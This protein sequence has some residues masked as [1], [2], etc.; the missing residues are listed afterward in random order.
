MHFLRVAGVALLTIS[1]VAALLHVVAPLESFLAPAATTVRDVWTLIHS[2]SPQSAFGGTSDSP[3]SA[4]GF[5][6]VFW[7]APAWMLI[8]AAGL[9]MLGLH[10]T[11]RVLHTLM[12]RPLS[13]NNSGERAHKASRNAVLYTEVGAAL[14]SSRG[15]FLGAA[16]FSGVSNL[17]M[18]TGSF[19]ML[20]VY[21]RVLPSRSIPTLVALSCLVVILFT[22]QG[23]L[24]FIRGRILVRAAIILD[25]SLG[26]RV[27]ETAVRLPLYMGA[28]LDPAQPVRDL[29]TVRSFL[30][31][32]GPIA[33]F[34][35]PWV[36]MYLGII[37]IFH[38]L[39]GAVALIGAILLIMLTLLTEFRTRGPVRAATEYGVI[40]QRLT[41]ASTRNAEVLTAIGL[42]KR[43]SSRW[44]EANRAYIN[45]QQRASDV[46]GGFTA[47]SRVLRM[48]LQ[49][50]VLAVG[51][52]LV[53]AQEATAGIIIAGAILMARALAPVDLAIANWQGFVK[54]RQ[55]WQRLSGL[56]AQLPAK[57]Q[58]LRLPAPTTSLRVESVSVAPPGEQT[59]AL[60][61][62]TFALT[63]G[64]GL[65]IIGPSG[66]G[67]SS[68][69]RAMV[70]VWPLVRGRIS[71]DRASLD[72]W[73]AEDLGRAVGYLPQ[74]VELFAGT[75]AENI[76]RFDEEAD[77]QAI[78]AAA[79]LAAVHDLI[80]SLPQGYETRIGEPGA[81]LSPGQQQRIALARALYG[82]P[83]LV[84]LD[85]PD[86]SLDMEGQLALTR[87][88]PRVRA[89]GGIVVVIS[90][91]PNVLEGVDLL[92]A[93][94]RGRMFAFGPKEIVLQKLRRPTGT[95]TETLKVITDSA[96]AK[97]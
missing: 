55:S 93:M 69:A 2:Q 10:R 18:L 85:E 12:S 96:R 52:Y 23:V 79:A 53:I 76:G 43:L 24:D 15:I 54:A 84:V 11:L 3:S 40:R 5:F 64:Q 56:L 48:M 86:A 73:S 19:F 89:R 32:S 58:P 72:Q 46:A 90:H 61:D 47:I 13:G 78:L 81:E 59:L 29:E 41:D 21:D 26:E 71:L 22:A 39:L 97:P 38:P 33:L 57:Q 51:A 35:L 62:V 45:E 80:V 60:H 28:R 91:R 27:Y 83:F 8:G 6:R 94:Q 20:Q 14:A 65:G 1:V 88:I 36:L 67:K 92:L 74:D 66:S 37:Y 4:V 50:G 7:A 63:G 49:S 17:L 44:R 31:S 75:V 68:L 42:T 9:A 77:P 34:D 25:E 16:F 30:S 95:R 82:N 70:G 87:A